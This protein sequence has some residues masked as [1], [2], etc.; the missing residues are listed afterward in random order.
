MR[1]SGE[2][3][4]EERPAIN[5]LLADVESCKVNNI[6]THKIDRFT[7]STKN[8]IELVELFNQRFRGV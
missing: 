7:R 6:L 4:V 3:Y 1:V 5:R 2:K 8:L